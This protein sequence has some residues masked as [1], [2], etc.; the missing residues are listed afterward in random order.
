M[1]QDTSLWDDNLE[2]EV[3]KFTNIFEFEQW[4]DKNN[5]KDRL[6]VLVHMNKLKRQGISNVKVSLLFNYG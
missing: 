6:E 4:V 2:N 1:E 5:Y 3:N